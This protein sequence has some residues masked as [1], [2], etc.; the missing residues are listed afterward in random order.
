MRSQVR[1]EGVAPAHGSWLLL[2]SALLLQDR[3]P[4]PLAAAQGT[5]FLDGDDGGDHVS[6]G[7][8]CSMLVDGDKA[9]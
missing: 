1:R 8:T 2:C 9:T 5:T 6:N 7:G 3:P 4:G